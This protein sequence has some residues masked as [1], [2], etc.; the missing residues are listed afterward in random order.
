MS[1]LWK[2]LDRSIGLREALKSFFFENQLSF[3]CFSFKPSLIVGMMFQVFFSIGYALLSAWAYLFPY[4]RDLQLAIGITSA[5]LLILFYVLDVIFK[6]IFLIQYF[7]N[8]S[9]NDLRFKRKS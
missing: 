3:V 8:C 5:P 7:F 6:A 9:M 4:W 1:I 2:L